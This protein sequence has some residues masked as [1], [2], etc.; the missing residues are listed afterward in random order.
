MFGAGNKKIKWGGKGEGVINATYVC[1]NEGGNIFRP[2]EVEDG[3]R[4]MFA[5]REAY[6]YTIPKSDLASRRQKDES[7]FAGGSV[8]YKSMVWTGTFHGT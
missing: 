4:I 8:G 7:W 1:T 3:Y 5:A 6:S 2:D